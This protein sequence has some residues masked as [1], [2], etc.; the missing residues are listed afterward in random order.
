M[1][2]KCDTSQNKHII[3][4]KIKMTLW[5]V[6]EFENV[7]PNCEVEDSLLSPQLL[8]LNDSPQVPELNYLGN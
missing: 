8:E 4:R 7:E 3:G 6:E 1:D 2:R 5:T